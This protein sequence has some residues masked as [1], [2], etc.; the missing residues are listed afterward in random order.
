METHNQA[1]WGQRCRFTA[2][3]TK[4][5]ENQAALS[6]S[7]E[8]PSADLRCHMGAG[9]ALGFPPSAEN[10]SQ[11]KAVRMVSHQGGA[12]RWEKSWV[13]YQGPGMTDAPTAAALLWDAP[14]AVQPQQL[15]M[16]KRRGRE[17][18]P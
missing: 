10:N 16:I 1:D 17:A 3:I 7:Q 13:N 6:R 12:Y 4:V 2:Q 8:Q 9:L 11:K 18:P 14:I 5:Q 15:F